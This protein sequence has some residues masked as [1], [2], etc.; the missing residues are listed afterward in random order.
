MSEPIKPFD[1]LDHNYTPEE[2]LQHI[3]ARVAFSLGLQPTSENEYKFWHARRMAFIQCSLTG[4]SLSWFIR[5][6]DTYKQDWHAFVQAFNKQ[7]SSQ[8][9]AYY[10]QVEALNL[11]KK[12]N[13]TVRHFTLKV[14]QL[15]V[16]QFKYKTCYAT[17][18]NDVGKISTPF[19]IRLKPNAQFIAQRPSKAPIHY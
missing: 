10:A 5:S 17:H 9:K 6:N 12:F 1:S 3:D 19:R 8:K 14:Q 16:Q 11:S 4:T 13:E 7:F 2:Y 18:K 15:K